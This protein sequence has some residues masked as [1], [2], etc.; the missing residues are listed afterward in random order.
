MHYYSA[1]KGVTIDYRID[2]SKLEIIT[3]T[4]MSW[5]TRDTITT[6]FI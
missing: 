1:V 2:M 5:A 3:L 6:P 4:E